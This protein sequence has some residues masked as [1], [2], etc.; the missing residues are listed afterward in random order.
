MLNL[1]Y[2]FYAHEEVLY[3]KTSTHIYIHTYTPTHTP[4]TTYMKY[5]LSDKDTFFVN[6]TFAYIAE[7]NTIICNFC[8]TSNKILPEYYSEYYC[9]NK[10]LYV[11]HII[12]FLYIVVFLQLP[13]VK[14]H[15][16]KCLHFGACKQH[17]NC[18]LA[19]K[20]FYFLKISYDR[21]KCLELFFKHI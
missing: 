15:Q 20:H 17:S 2:C 18:L 7:Q 8:N 16:N 13:C 11:V 14:R 5:A 9:L 12:C 21:K 10:N 19:F 6:T 1:L 4:H 3:N